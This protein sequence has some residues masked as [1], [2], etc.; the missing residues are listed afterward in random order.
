VV[1]SKIS[2]SVGAQ[3]YG[4]AHKGRVYV[5]VFIGVSVCACYEGLR[6]CVYRGECVC[7]L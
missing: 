2:K 5:R 3:S 7:V 4:G 1:T 6:T